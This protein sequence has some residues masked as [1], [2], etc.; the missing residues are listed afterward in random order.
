VCSSDLIKA[1]TYNCAH[2]Y[3]DALYWRACGAPIQCIDVQVRTIIG[4]CL[5]EQGNRPCSGA[6]AAVSHQVY[7]NMRD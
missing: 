2:L 5:D 4:H 1:M 6:S 7:K 3:V